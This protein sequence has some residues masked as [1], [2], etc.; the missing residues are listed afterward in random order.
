MFIATDR[1]VMGY[2][3][4]IAIAVLPSLDKSLRKSFYSQHGGG[5]NFHG[6]AL[7]VAGGGG[8]IKLNVCKSLAMM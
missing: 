6:S 7:C 1:A 8:K 5:A 4:G 2:Y 3:S